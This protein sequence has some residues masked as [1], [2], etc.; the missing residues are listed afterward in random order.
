M[1]TLALAAVALVAVP[2]VAARAA[3][4]PDFDKVQIKAT[5]ISG[6]VWMLEGVGPSFSGGNIGVCAGPD[7]VL[8][9]DDKFSPLAAKIQAALKGVS[10]KPVRFVVN[11]HYH[12]DHTEGNT[13][14]G[15]IATIIAHDATRKRLLENG[16]Q[17]D[18]KAAPA[19]ALPIITFDDEVELHLNGQDIHAVHYPNAHT[20]TDVVVTFKQAN[21]VHM[22]DEFF[23]GMYPFI[24][25]EG[26]GSIKGLIANVEKILAQIPADAK[27][28]PGHGPLATVNDLRAFLG[29]LK[30][31]TAVVEAAMK[32]GKTV[33]QLKKDK[34]FAQLDA[35]WGAGFLK[36][37][38]FIDELW[39]DLSRK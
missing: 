28:I 36:A 30:E 9:V 26:G 25:V 12:G 2:W 11:T 3:D 23:N 18:G 24:D 19:V 32:A 31:S 7:G 8:L 13:V 1:R 22:G 20:D 34:P 14:F 33:D 37:D 10:D 17:R 39:K 27:I 38:D 16:F 5:Q 29:M 6:P 15:A 35:K 4:K 21:V